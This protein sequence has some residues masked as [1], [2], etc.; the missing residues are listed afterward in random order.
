LTGVNTAYNFEKDGTFTSGIRFHNTTWN[1]NEMLTHIESLNGSFQADYYYLPN[2]MRI[3]ATRNGQSRLYQLDMTGLGD[4]LAECDANGNPLYYYIHGFGLMARIEAATNTP[5][6]Y[7]ADVRGSTIAM[8]RPN[9]TI[10]HKYAYTPYGDIA[11]IQEEDFNPFRYV[12]TLG[13]MYEDSAFYFMRARYYDAGEHRFLSEDPIW[14]E[15]LYSYTENNPVMGV[16]P[17]GRVNWGRVTKGAITASAATVSLI[18]FAASAPISMP[19]ILVV[20]LMGAGSIITGM[21]EMGIGFAE[22][23]TN[24][25]EMER[26][27]SLVPTPLTTPCMAIG[28]MANGEGGAIRGN[29]IC[30]KIETVAS[31]VMGAQGL[32]NPESMLQVG[33]DLV[34]VL[35]D[36]HS[37][38]SS[39]ENTNKS[40]NYSPHFPEYNLNFSIYSPINYSPMNYSPMNYSPM[41]YSPINMCYGSFK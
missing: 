1:P 29:K 12:G 24:K 8:S 22:N 27:S 40:Q 4:I 34:S 23:E 10:S 33:N 26:L 21:A 15:N 5:R 16:D 7:H 3:A 19:F 17:S 31:L 14:A 25:A 13:V 18:L 39:S 6:F 9:G 32:K 37:L 36:T 2:G 38:F 35:N 20:S 41:N 30:G 11:D 28:Y